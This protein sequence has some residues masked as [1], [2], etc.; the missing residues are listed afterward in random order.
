MIPLEAILK[1]LKAFARI[2]FE[3]LLRCIDLLNQGGVA[4]GLNRYCEQ[5]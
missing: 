4:Q 1:L 3:L 5:N 2:C